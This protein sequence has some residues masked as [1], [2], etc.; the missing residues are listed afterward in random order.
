MISR[1]LLFITFPALLAGLPARAV[2]AADA[3]QL[4]VSEPGN[5]SF[6]IAPGAR[7]RDCEKCPEMT[8]LLSN[9]ITRGGT[10]A[11]Q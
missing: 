2:E 5:Y 7:F 8:V 6:S 1:F 3:P 4:A 9:G 11:K 10:R